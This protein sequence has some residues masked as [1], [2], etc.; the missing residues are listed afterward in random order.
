MEAGK[1]AV[2]SFARGSILSLLARED[3]DTDE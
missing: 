2:A 3:D 1:L